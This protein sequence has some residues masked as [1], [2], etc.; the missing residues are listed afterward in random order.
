MRSVSPIVE[1]F[2]AAFRRPSVTFGEIV[3]RWS[4]GATA[5]ALFFF[6]FFEYL[7]TLPVT[8]GEMLLLKTRQPYLVGQAI[9]H[10]LHG[11]LNRAVMSLMLAAVLMG[12]LWIVAASVGRIATVEALISYFR[13]KF[14]IGPD[15]GHG[16][17]RIAAS[18]AATSAF[19][20]LLRL[21]FLRAVVALA[22]IVGFL[23]AG[24]MAGL[25]S[26]AKNPQPGLAFVL[27]LPLAALVWLTWWVLNWLL[28]LAGVLAVRDQGSA[29]D[30]I[31][32]AVGMCRDR[33][34]AV[35]A[36]STWSG[37]AHLLVFG[38]GTTAVSVPLGFTGIV[39]GQIVLG[40]AM[41]VT[42]IYLAVVDWLYMAR[43]AGYVCIVELPEALFAPPPP[44]PVVPIPVQTTIDRD[45]PILSDIP[46][47]IPET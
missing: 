8:S 34:G 13:E 24:I 27:F 38:A 40:A 30:A 4:V 39:P 22:A 1:G 23:G 17:G 25:A 20:A 41:V 28:S 19:P 21:N 11:S 6:G 10:I 2:R 47:L 18:D 31:S 7:N 37:L 44:A 12:V 9:A 26:P 43:M 3:W 32:D 42:L 33:T 16:I 45:E 46:G 14:A 35:F 29:M 15:F 36:V 5:T